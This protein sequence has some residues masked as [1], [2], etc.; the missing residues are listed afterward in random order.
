MVY[1]RVYSNTLSMSAVATTQ[2]EGGTLLAQRKHRQVKEQ[3]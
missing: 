3:D 2:L 1:S